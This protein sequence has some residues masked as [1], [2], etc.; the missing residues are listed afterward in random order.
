MRRIH[1]HLGTGFSGA[2]H[3]CIEEFGDNATDEEIE[4]SFQDWKENYLD[5]GWWDEDA[6]N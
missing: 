3:D 5:C 2:D 6:E 1:F 4:E